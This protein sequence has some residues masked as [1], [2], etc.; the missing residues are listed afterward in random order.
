[1]KN[2]AGKRFTR[3]IAFAVSL[4]LIASCVPLSGLVASAYRLNDEVVLEDV[5]FDENNINLRLGVMS[6]I[7][8]TYAS[9][10]LASIQ[11]KIANYAKT[12][13]VLDKMAG[14]KLDALMLCGDYTS[15]GREAQGRTFIS[16]SK[17]VMDAVNRGKSDSEKTKWIMAY[18]N[19]DTE[20]NGNMPISQWE[21]LFNE[22]GMLNDVEVAPG[23]IGAYKLTLNKGDKTYYVFSIETDTYNVPS[24]M[25]R[26]DVLEWLDA[27]LATASSDDY[28]YVIAHGPIKESLVYGS[29]MAF[30]KDADWGTAESGYTGT[31]KEDGAPT[32]S[33]I[34]A[35]L[36][37]Y[38]NVVYLSG[39]THLTDVLD[40]SLMQNS[41]T[42][43]NVGSLHSSDFYSTVTKF[44]DEDDGNKCTEKTRFGYS[45]FVEVDNTGNMRITRVKNAQNFADV[46]IEYTETHNNDIEL[47]NRN[48]GDPEY[49]SAAYVKSITVNSVSLPDESKLDERWLLPAPKA[50]KSH[51]RYFSKE[52]ACTP[53]FADNASVTIEDPII[54]N[55]KF[56]GTV[57]FDTATCSTL[58]HRYEINLY[59]QNGNLIGSRWALGNWIET[60]SGI[61][62]N[63]ETHL[64]ATKLTYIVRFDT[65]VNADAVRAS[66]VAVDE[67]GGRSREVFSESVECIS[68]YSMPVYDST[69]ATNY[70]DNIAAVG[71]PGSGRITQSGTKFSWDNVSVSVNEGPW[72]KVHFFLDPVKLSFGPVASNNYNGWNVP[73]KYHKYFTPFGAED[74][75]AYEADFKT[76]AVK[77]GGYI[78]FAVRMDGTTETNS[79]LYTGIRISDT[80]TYLVLNNTGI[81][82]SSKFKLVADGST[83]HITILSEP[84]KISVWIDGTEIFQRLRFTNGGGVMYPT[85]FIWGQ[86]FKGSVDGQKMYWCENAVPGYKAQQD[87]DFGPLTKNFFDGAKL[88]Y[89]GSANEGVAAPTLG[90]NSVTAS[91]K[92]KVSDYGW[93]SI[94]LVLDN[95][96]AN[97]FNS[98]S[99]NVAFMSSFKATDEVAFEFEYTASNFH[100]Q[101][102]R[103]YAQFYLPVRSG[104]SAKEEVSLLIRSNG[105]FGLFIGDKD[106][107]ITG[108]KRFLNDGDTHKIK[109]VS[110]NTHM[111]L[112]IDDSPVYEN[113]S[114]QDT[115]NVRYGSENRVLNT[116]KYLP[117]FGFSSMQGAD[118]KFDKIKIYQKGVTIKNYGEC[119]KSNNLMGSSY[120]NVTASLGNNISG[121]TWNGYEI[122]MDMRY[123]SL[124]EKGYPQ[125]RYYGND[126]KLLSGYTFDSEK[127]YALSM[128]VKKS[129]DNT[130]PVVEGDS[131]SYTSRLS[132]AI[133][134]YN[135]IEVWCFYENGNLIAYAENREVGR[136]Q[137]GIGNNEYF[138]YTAVVTQF[139][140]EI[141]MNGILVYKWAA[142][143]PSKFMRSPNFR[144]NGTEMMAQEIAVYEVDNT[145]E[146][147]G[148]ISDL[149]DF[150]RKK[151]QNIEA[152]KY[153]VPGDLTNAMAVLKNAEDMLAA[154]NAGSD[155]A[156]SD[157]LSMLEEIKAL[158]INCTAY[159]NF[160]YDGSA[161]IGVSNG[162][163]TI[164]SGS[165]FGYGSI[166]LF[167]AGKCPIGEGDVYVLE[168]DIKVVAIGENVKRIGF[169]T[170]DTADGDVMIQGTTQYTNTKASGWNHQYGTTN[171]TRPNIA[172]AGFTCHVKFTVTP[173]VG[174]RYYMTSLDGKTLYYDYTA[175]WDVLRD[176]SRD[177]SKISPRF[178][179]AN[180]EVELSNIYAGYVLEH[181]N[182]ALQTVLE[183]TAVADVNSYVTASAD[184]YKTALADAMRISAKYDDY[185]KSEIVAAGNALTNAHNAL[186]AKSVLDVT[187]ANGTDTAESFILVEGDE[188]PRNERIG[189]KFILSW[190]NGDETYEGKVASG[191][192]LSA[193]Y[194][195]TQMMTVKY[196]LTKGATAASD[197]LN[198]RFIASVDGVSRY[199]SVGWL[200]SLTNSDMFKKDVGKGVADREST[201]VYERVI[202]NGNALTPND[203]YG[204]DYAK[205]FYAFEIKN[206]PQSQYSKP[207]YVRAYVTM[208]D[209][210]VVYGDTKTVVLS[211]ILK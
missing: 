108:G 179:F 146:I 68:T 155:V 102:N 42:A 37:K 205:Y 103:T 54:R 75:F 56:T 116:D 76:D 198:C 85:A 130:P 65:T 25:F 202:A 84:K 211:D 169:T 59:D 60:N 79:N 206:I 39:H 58:I 207:I 177:P 99:D 175:P 23:A 159:N 61:V 135:G 136:K 41:Y 145:E 13:L 192:N 168:A 124:A 1:M 148:K 71:L 149:A 114:F 197:K 173:G 82:S 90:F 49:I 113:L 131:G 100:T 38:P 162:I 171:G 186:K 55:S 153:V 77:N 80:G 125:Y 157:A 106:A 128:I 48:S 97:S 104:G 150:N 94:W 81:A 183:N 127:A 158:E 72:D 199:K 24:N 92:D 73:Y 189:T 151:I 182:E 83:H 91:V 44:L 208:E 190:K 210:T 96:N 121:F 86:Q 122:Y 33:E 120:A 110:T 12:S 195:E 129:N 105:V 53:V 111:S 70:F 3:V 138:K 67:F 87:K 26:V 63:G 17:A 32:T 152:A 166:A 193:D 154:Y 34:D 43:I 20:W 133:G 181:Y 201:K 180:M 88:V 16:A 188:L 203:V 36:K 64:N 98:L 170:Y 118:F 196:Q 95:P 123:A 161:S 184:A 164:K 172:V 15:H 50:D 89:G 163:N 5:N 117:V 27:Q 47:T 46:S 8:L 142:P 200:F 10:P 119:D 107:N 78:N 178:Y 109:V 93:Q 147:I 137:V 204:K 18:G 187:V 30:E 167:D 176:N 156:E 132:W 9:D 66:V 139:G 29:D 112:W 144:V 7:H 22:Y 21:A 4:L 57:T 14:G 35:L 52:R 74:T 2:H 101:G 209:G 165:T 6:D 69:K 19:H 11:A 62:N 194:V 126:I 143:D 140:Y 174:I 40:S 31:C 115:Y 28:V 191:L 185:S 134:S 141:Y 51:L 160:I 45:L